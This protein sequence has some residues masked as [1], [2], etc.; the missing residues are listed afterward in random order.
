MHY[1]LHVYIVYVYCNIAKKSFNIVHFI[2][3]PKAKEIPNRTPRFPMHPPIHEFWDPYN[4]NLRAPMPRFPQIAS[5]K[6]V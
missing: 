1:V 4:G 6:E 3:S 5:H 2:T